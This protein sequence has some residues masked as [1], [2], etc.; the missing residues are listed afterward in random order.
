MK[1]ASTKGPLM[2][3]IA[4]FIWGTAFVA[5]SMGNDVGPFTFLAYRSI[6]GFL[7]LMF[8]IL[9]INRRKSHSSIKMEK[10]DK[11]KNY[12][13]SGIICGTVLFAAMALQQIGL[14]YTS[15]GKAG[16]LTALYII[17]VPI[18]GIVLKKIPGIKIVICVIIATAGTYLLSVTED[19]TISPGDVYIILSAVVF[20]VH[21]LVIDHYS[22]KAN[23]VKLSAAQFLVCAIIALIVSVVIEKPAVSEILDV[24]FP[25]LYAGIMSS[26]IAFTLQ[27]IGQRGTQPTVASLI[28][29]LESVFALLAGMLILGETLNNN[30]VIGC[31]LVFLAVLLAQVP[32][33]N[34]FKLRRE[35]T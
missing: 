18:I 19:F 35:E 5:Q 24:A 25:I 15:A 33:K 17:F 3:L 31:V 29:S 32:N 21:I 12:I 8:F 13:K 16:F 34:P 2:L 23:A 26:G 10:K 27:V 30:E 14:I 4:S 20:S 9:I 6:V 28:M 1:V 11:N 22:K 7:F